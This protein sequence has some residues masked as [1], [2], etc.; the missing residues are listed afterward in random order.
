MQVFL[1]TVSTTNQAKS[2]AVISAKYSH[3]IGDKRDSTKSR[4]ACPRDS[5]LFEKIP[6]SYRLLL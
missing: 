4:E 1:A 3:W 6:V 2:N 5:A